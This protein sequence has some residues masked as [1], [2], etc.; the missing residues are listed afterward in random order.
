[1]IPC[2][3]SSCMLPTWTT[4]L[5]LMMDLADSESPTTSRFLVFSFFLGQKLLLVKCPISQQPSFPLHL[6][7]QHLL[8]FA[9]ITV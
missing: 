4:Y 6:D 8:H 5:I 1:M 3:P 2:T 7:R 9:L